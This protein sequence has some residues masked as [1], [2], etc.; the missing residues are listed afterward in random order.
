MTTNIIKTHPCK[1]NSWNINYVFY[2]T[3]PEAPF[4]VIDRDNS[5]EWISQ[6]KYCPECGERL[7]PKNIK[8]ITTFVEED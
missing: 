7:L 1:I 2:L 3:Q 5:E 6:I 8:V 4:W